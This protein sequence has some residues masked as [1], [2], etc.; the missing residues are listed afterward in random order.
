VSSANINDI[1]ESHKGIHVLMEYCDGLNGE[2]F[3][4]HGDR[5]SAVYLENALSAL[6]T[7]NTT[8]SVSYKVNGD[9]FLEKI[10]QVIANT[11]ST[12]LIPLLTSTREKIATLFEKYKTVEVLIGPCHGDLTLS[13]MILSPSKGLVLID[14]LDTYFESPLQDVAKLRQDFYYGWARRICRFTLVP[15]PSRTSVKLHP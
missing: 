12:G 1:Q 7:R 14:F 2:G 6:L 3:A 10:S 9:P 8:N 11:T 5:A 15:E 13:N 4:I